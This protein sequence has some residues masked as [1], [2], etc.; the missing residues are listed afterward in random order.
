M[1]KRHDPA[2]VGQHGRPWT[3]VLHVVDIG[4][5]SDCTINSRGPVSYMYAVDVDGIKV[6]SLYCDWLHSP[7]VLYY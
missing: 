6:R 4:L 2:N 7:T 1:K 5:L 3:S